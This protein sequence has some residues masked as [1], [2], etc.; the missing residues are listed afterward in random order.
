MYESKCLAAKSDDKI[1]IIS[2]YGYVK[3]SGT[4]GD[5]RVNPYGPINLKSYDFWAPPLHVPH[6]TYEVLF[7]R[8][9]TVDKIEINWKVAPPVH[10]IQIETSM[11]FWKTLVNANSQE[12]VDLKIPPTEIIAVKIILMD[13]DEN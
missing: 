10:E 13:M 1:E 8:P 9:Y 6:A 12:N 2:Q 5:S 11:T 4:L 7:D 3:V